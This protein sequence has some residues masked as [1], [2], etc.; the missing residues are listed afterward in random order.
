MG[1]NSVLYTACCFAV[2]YLSFFKKEVPNVAERKLTQ[3]GTDPRP[4]GPEAFCAMLYSVSVDVG[5]DVSIVEWL[6]GISLDYGTSAT[7]NYG[8]LERIKSNTCD[9]YQEIFV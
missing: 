5:G 7:H 2:Q 1:D 9:L 6:N 8:S 3:V 4:G